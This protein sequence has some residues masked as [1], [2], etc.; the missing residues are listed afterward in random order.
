MARRGSAGK[1]QAQ[2]WSNLVTRVYEPILCRVMQLA[3]EHD[4]SPWRAAEE[5]DEE[6]TQLTGDTW[7][8]LVASIRATTDGASRA[9]LLDKT[10]HVEE[11]V[12]TIVVPP[13]EHKA[14]EGLVFLN[15]PAATTHVLAIDPALSC[16]WAWL[17][18]DASDTLVS[19]EVGV[20]DVQGGTDGQRCS[21]LQTQLRA[22]LQTRT[23]DKVVMESYMG[24]ARP[25]DAIGYMLRGAIAMVLDDVTTVAPQ[26]WKS[27]MGVKGNCKHKRDVKEAIERKLGVQFPSHVF[28]G[29]RW[30]TFRHD[31]SDAAGIG[32]CA[33]LRFPRTS[34]SRRPDSRA[35]MGK[36]VGPPTAV[37]PE[38]EPEPPPTPS[39]TV[40][41]SKDCLTCGCTLGFGHSGVC[42]AIVSGSRAGRGTTT[43]RRLGE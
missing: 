29:T 16:G 30:L 40:P 1:A 15:D 13:E 5:L 10:L 34:S 23:P 14:E 26:T 21:N 39:K 37:P 20:F 43:K 19:V 9:Q 32:L 6:R 41:T 3:E 38:P 36:P 27:N 31:A 42:N 33:S 35:R 4:M 25:T 12:Q 22:F 18:L 2:A 24:H 28:V 7:T 17:S 11:E 8:K